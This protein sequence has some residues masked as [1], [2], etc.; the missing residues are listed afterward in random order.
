MSKTLRRHLNGHVHMQVTWLSSCH[1][2]HIQDGRHK[3]PLGLEV[4]TKRIG[5]CALV[6]G[7]HANLAQV[8]EEV[9]AASALVGR[10]KAE[11]GEAAAGR[12]QIG[13]GQATQP[14]AQPRRLL[15]TGM[16]LG[17][18][19]D[20]E[21]C[22]G[23]CNWQAAQQLQRAQHAQPWAAGESHCSDIKGCSWGDVAAVVDV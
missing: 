2:K 6:V 7:Q 17:I 23:M 16:C 8:L 12:G 20:P 10:G 21:F 5:Q 22:I 13:R 15:G 3:G 19:I 9:C 1:S 4:V 18:A 11:R 14:Q